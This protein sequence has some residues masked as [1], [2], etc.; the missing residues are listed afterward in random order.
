MKQALKITTALIAIIIT[1]ILIS[2]LKNNGT[3]EQVSTFFIM[4][5]VSVVGCWGSWLK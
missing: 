4:F 1:L 3:Q 2:L 5:V